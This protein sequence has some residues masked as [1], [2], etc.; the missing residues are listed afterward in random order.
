ME[1]FVDR[2][3]SGAEFREVLLDGARF[4]GVSMRNVTIEGLD[5]DGMTI[6]GVEVAPFVHAELE[7]RH[8]ERRLLWSDDL[9]EL[10]EGWRML[11]ERWSETIE[12]LR[13]TAGLERRSVNG[14]WSPLETLRHLLF[15]H[16]AWFR[17]GAMGLE[18]PY[19]VLGIPGNWLAPGELPEVDARIDTDA[20]PSLDEVLAERADR[21]AEVT[22]WLHSADATSA[23]APR[24]DLTTKGWPPH[25][26]ERCVLE[27]VKVV[28]EEEW[29][30]LHYTVRDLDLIEAE[31]A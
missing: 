29:W 14:E 21:V 20:D 1:R 30:H 26:P 12:R 5:F 27:A 17:R 24:P 6:N 25:Q 8:P 4:S 28:P 9:D 16:D 19:G 13:R 7:R 11:Q 31:D 3:L 22:A 18:T 2:D 15:A 23:A 10:R